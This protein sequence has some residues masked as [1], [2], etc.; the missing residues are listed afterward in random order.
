MHGAERQDT[1]KFW[2]EPGRQKPFR[3]EKDQRQYH[4]RANQTAQEP[5]TPF[6]EKNEFETAQIHVRKKLCIL[7][8]LLIILEF[9]EP[10]GGAQ[11]RNDAGQGLPF[12]NG[13]ARFGEPGR[14]ADNHHQKDESGEAPKPNRNRAMG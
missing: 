10:F 3:P 9:G 12:G 2:L 5:V 14:A 11:R 4:G 13:K 7:R 8:Y 6:E 1:E